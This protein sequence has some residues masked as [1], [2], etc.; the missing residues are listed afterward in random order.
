V[1]S[2]GSSGDASHLL[3]LQQLDVQISLRRPRGTGDVPQPGRGEV[4]GGLT[5]R[6]CACDARAPSDLAQ[7]PLEQI[8][9]A[10]ARASS[11]ELSRRR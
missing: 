7:D 6:E 4:E 1:P 5:I 2:T 9:S 3:V 10:N 8:I 11:T